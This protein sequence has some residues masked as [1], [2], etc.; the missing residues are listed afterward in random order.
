MFDT[1]TVTQLET[2]R[3]AYY[4]VAIGAAT[5]IKKYGVAGRAMQVERIS[6]AEALESLRLV[7]EALAQRQNPFGDMISV[8]FGEPE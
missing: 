7:D 8:D 6:P 2:L 4:Q 5:S 1:L 3:D